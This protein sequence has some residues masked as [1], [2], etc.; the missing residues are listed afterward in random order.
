VSDSG[1]SIWFA[2]SG[3]YGSTNG[4]SVFTH[5]VNFGVFQTNSRNLQQATNELINSLQRGNGNLRSRTGYQRTTLDGRDALAIGLNN[6]HEAT[7]RQEIVSVITTQLRNGELLY[8]IAVAPNDDFA[9]YQNVFQN[10]LRSLQ[11]NA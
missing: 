11:L 9:N 4:Q 5:G 7:G 10:I 2:P 8:M 3:A 6:A 1:N